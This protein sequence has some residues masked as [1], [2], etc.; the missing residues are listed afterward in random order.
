MRKY[1]I[2]RLPLKKNSKGCI[3]TL[4]IH[5]EL[6][7]GPNANTRFCGCSSPIISPLYL[8]IQPMMDQAI[9]QYY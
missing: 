3:A 1:I 5:W 6:V 2:S 8:W 4:S 9:L 7:P